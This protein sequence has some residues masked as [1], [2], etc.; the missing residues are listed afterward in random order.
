[1]IE[2]ANSERE[3]GR[4]TIL[5]GSGKRSYASTTIRAD[6]RTAQHARQGGA[7]ETCMGEKSLC[8]EQVMTTPMPDP[9]PKPGQEPMPRP[10][11][12]PPIEDPTPVPTIID[13]PPTL[14]SPGIPVEEP[15]PS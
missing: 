10:A 11:P 1:M 7:R 5:F 2:R 14:P 3:S 12:I 6:C 15:L 9:G 4:T 13:L 8:E